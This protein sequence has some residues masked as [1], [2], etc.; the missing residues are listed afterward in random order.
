[1][2]YSYMERIKE[3][4]K[5]SL[6][7]FPRT[8]EEVV[9]K[10]YGAY[11]LLVKQTMDEMKIHNHLVP[12]FTTQEED[13]PYMLEAETDHKKSE[14]VTYII[15]N[16][17]VLSNW[18][19]SWQSCQK[20]SQLDLWQ[21]KNLLFLGTPRL[22][23]Y[24]IIHSKGKSLTLIDLDKNVTVALQKKYDSQ[25]KAS[26]IHIQTN[27]INFLRTDSDK[28]DVVF[29]DPPWYVES[30]FSWL[31]KAAE[32]ITPE[33]TIV[34][35]L[36]PYLLR[37]T[38]SEERNRI[39]KCCR[40]FAKSVINI[41]EYLE[42]DIPTFEKKE[43]EHAGLDLQSNWKISDLV[44]LQNPFDRSAEWERIILNTDYDNWAEFN[45]LGIRWFINRSTEMASFDSTSLLSLVG[46]SFYL[47]SP[48]HRN[49]QLKQANLLSSQG[50]GL[51]VSN[52]ERLLSIVAELNRSP[53]SPSFEVVIDRLIIDENSKRI[54][55]QLKDDICE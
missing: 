37:P 12:L 41:P 5:V 45:W 22:F 32:L 10:C 27:D 17:P 13:I 36:F 19:F 24:F 52:P 33:G 3:C 9:K 51:A 49:K 6:R 30:Y 15:E 20:L 1:M 29:L 43:L 11:P 47:K 46:T 55:K 14:L 35:S 38:A 48:S 7:D 54:L 44:I 18:Y 25:K 26:S 21:D 40:K 39:F 34:F 8:F 4:V 42:Y 2:Q 50:H 28:Y 31:S 23:E 16:N 53:L